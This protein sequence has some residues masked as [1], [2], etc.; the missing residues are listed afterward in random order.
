MEMGQEEE[1]PDRVSRA[2]S[3]SSLPSQNLL[4]SYPFIRFP[5]DE[6]DEGKTNKVEELMKKFD[7]KERKNND[8]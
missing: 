7:G 3:C 8:D 6:K 5:D 1:P 2:S 4:E